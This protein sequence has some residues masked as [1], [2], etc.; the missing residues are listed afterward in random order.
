MSRSRWW[1]WLRGTR[2]RH[3]FLRAGVFVA[4]LFM[5]LLGAFMWLFSLLLAVPPLF[6]G[7]WV[8]SREFHWGHR[9]YRA[10]LRRAGSLWAR[11]KLRPARWGLLT[12]AGLAAAVAGY[13]AWGY[14]GLPGVT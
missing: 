5:M 2:G 12:A 1:T 10:F 14:F 8:W 4:G 3:Q 11:I 9:L 6:V 7:L 13:W